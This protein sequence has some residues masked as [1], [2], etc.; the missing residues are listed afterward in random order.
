MKKHHYQ[1]KTIWT[2]NRGHGTKS[3]H[4]YDRH[5]DIKIKNKPTIHGSSDPAF[6]GDPACHNP[7]EQFVA[8]LSSCHMLWYLHLCATQGIVVTSYVDTASGVMEE[9]KDGSGQFVEVVLRP[10][11]KIEKEQMIHQAI[12]LH[13][14]AHEY[15]FIARSV[16]FPVRCEPEIKAVTE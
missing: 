9:N 6:S 15:C 16:N 13:K 8:D 14:S 10:E 5:F 7:E 11:I 3:Y 12:H 1:T 4:A 2:G